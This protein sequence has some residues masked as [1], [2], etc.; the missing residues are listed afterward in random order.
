MEADYDPEVMKDLQ[1]YL[2]LGQIKDIYN[3]ADN[4]KDKMLIR[5]LW[6]TGRRITEI[7]KVQIMDIDFDDPAIVWHIQKKTRR[8][9]GLRVK[10]DKRKRVPLDDF[11]YKLLKFYVFK[12]NLKGSCFLFPSPTNQLKPISRQA[13]F[14]IVRKLA[15]RAD[16]LQ[17][18]SKK[19]HPHHFRHCT[20]PDTLILNSEGIWK[21]YLTLKVGELVYTLNLDKE[22]IELQP[23]LK[24][25][26]Y[27]FNGQ[28]NYIKS[29]Y[30]NVGFT[31]EHNWVIKKRDWKNPKYG[32]WGNWQKLPFTKIGKHFKIRTSAQKK[33]GISIGKA[34]AGLLGW[35]LSDGCI[36]KRKNG[37]QVIVS[38]SLSANPSKVEYIKKLFEES[39]IK[40]SYH[41]SK[42][43]SNFDGKEYTMATF[44]FLKKE[45]S[46][47]FNWINPD[48]TP[49]WKIFQ[50]CGEE[51]EEIYKAMMLG[52]GSRGQEYCGQNPKRIEFF[53]VLSHFTN[54]RTLKRTGVLNVGKRKGEKK[55]RIFVSN[56]NCFDIK[57]C[58][59]SKEYYKGKVWCPTIKN[60]TFLAKSNDT[61]FWSGNSF[62]IAMAKKLKT[63][64]DIEKLRRIMDHSTLAITQ[65]YLQFGDQEMKDLLNQPDD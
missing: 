44:R 7:L 18:G 65:V 24:K 64:A 8:E 61:I 32:K 47:I 60:G 28:L 46:W 22:E 23:V 48:R 3:S 58:Y 31:D 50:L 27:N 14:K 40:Y 6:K 13:A 62:A 9:N 57:S 29:K 35:V 63:P 37:Y 25:N 5:L 26:I 53:R 52:C 30:I 20:R 54:R 11:T 56:R 51:L 19:A 33:E 42:N 12:M 2:N 1:G 4:I 45:Y 15:K 49:K 16:I 55:S 41:T 43:K 17:V 39:G 21:D 59:I 34:K 36:S 10:Y 38:Q